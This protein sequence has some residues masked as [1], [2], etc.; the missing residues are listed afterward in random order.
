MNEYEQQA[1][2]FLKATGA[3][4]A[5][6]YT[7]HRPHFEGEKEFRATYMITI[8]RD[9]KPAMAFPFGQSLV[10][11]W[12]FLAT[13]GKSQFGM[14]KAISGSQ[15]EG[16]DLLQVFNKT[17]CSGDDSNGGHGCY[18]VIRSSGAYG[19]RD[20]QIKKAEVVP[21]AYDILACMTKYDL[22]TFSDFCSDFGYDE[23]SRK[24]ETVYQAVRKEYQDLA[25]IFSSDELE[26]MSEIS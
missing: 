14:M 25:R 4:I 18:S 19:R 26:E 2:D 7:G 24:A 23:D 13:S 5:A 11:S 6:V 10:N 1:N 20:V 8:T 17:V 3:K 21:T 22:G 15:L 16:H 9:N 12:K